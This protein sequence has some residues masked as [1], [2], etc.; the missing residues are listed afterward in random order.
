MG[1]AAI[2]PRKRRVCSNEH[3]LTCFNNQKRYNK[4]IDELYGWLM[5]VSGVVL[6]VS[7][8]TVQYIVGYHHPLL[9]SL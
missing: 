4:F 2:G 6:C 5:I 8:Y 7:L 9:E 3:V 1:K